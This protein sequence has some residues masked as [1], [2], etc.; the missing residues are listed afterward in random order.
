LLTAD[1]TGQKIVAV[2][3]T[4]SLVGLFALVVAFGAKRIGATA[5]EYLTENTD[6]LALRSIERSLK[7]AA[8]AHP[9]DQKA[10]QATACCEAAVEADEEERSAA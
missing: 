1:P 9:K 3:Y 10:V 8:S 2:L 4:A 5:K 6:D 7:V